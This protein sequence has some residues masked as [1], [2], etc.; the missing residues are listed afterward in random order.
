[1]IA[2]ANVA[3]GQDAV[4]RS[5][6]A[7]PALALVAAIGLVVLSL[8][9]NAA[10]RGESSGDPLFWTGLVL[11]VAPVAWRLL[12]ARAT[13]SERLALC[14]VLGVSLYLMK[15]LHS[16]IQFTFH[17][18]L[19]HVRST[20]DILRSGS[21]FTPN[22]LVGAYAVYPGTE[23]VTAALAKLTGLSVFTAGALTIGVARVVM[24]PALFL[25][26]EEASASARWSSAATLIYVANPNYLFFDAQFAYESLALPLALMV[27]LTTVGRTGS[28]HE[29]SKAPWLVPVILGL[30]LVPTHHVTSLAVIVFLLLV[31]VATAVGRREL[32]SVIRTRPVGVA[33]TT[34]AAAGA[35]LAISGPR[36]SQELVPVV[37]RTLDAVGNLVV[38]A[39]SAKQPFATQGA[40]TDSTLARLIGLLAVALLLL[41]LAAGLWALLRRRPVPPLPTILALAA[42]AY[43]ATL[44][45]RLTAAGTETANRASEFL[46]VGLGYIVVLGAMWAW[47]VRAVG[48][49]RRRLAPRLHGPI[50]AGAVTVLILGGL[51]VGWAP[52][53]R[54]PGRYAP[55]ASSRSIDAPAVAAAHWAGDHLPVGAV[56]ATDGANSTLLTAYS[57]VNPQRG[58]I[59]GVPVAT[60]FFSPTFGSRERTIIRA[61]KIRYIIVDRRLS[62]GKPLSD[63]FFEGADP[64]IFKGRITSVALAK[65]AHVAALSLIYDSGALQVYDASRL[66]GDSRQ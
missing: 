23:I 19:G 42:L 25:L 29:A 33:I 40:A 3:E 30:A 9:D 52:Y 28:D 53:T 21:L 45:I 34:L 36:L 6:F 7:M 44:V 12:S 56:V 18:E 38:G 27:V 8:G 13:R 50:L 39:T 54:L 32:R 4:R 58:E 59:G 65:F 66:L 20:S 5:L 15:L 24:L 51:I 63:R 11:I 35:W 64:P 1:M 48:P 14:V 10:R 16:P 22:P 26:F 46:F 47:G 41:G 17:D 62:Q 61:D 55:G 37:T 49:I 60:L 2:G 31:S 57:Q 43:P